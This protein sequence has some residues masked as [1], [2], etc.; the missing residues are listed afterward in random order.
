MTAC[1]IHWLLLIEWAK[2]IFIFRSLSLAVSTFAQFA[3]VMPY[4]ARNMS[5]LFDRRCSEKLFVCSKLSRAS[6]QVDCSYQVCANFSLTPPDSECLTF[7][8]LG[9]MPL[10]SS[11][12]RLRISL[13]KIR[14]STQVFLSS[15]GLCGCDVMWLAMWHT[16]RCTYMWALERLKLQLFPNA[17]WHFRFGNTYRSYQL[18]WWNYLSHK[19]P[20]IKWLCLH[21]LRLCVCV[22][23]W[24]IVETVSRIGE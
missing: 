4:N 2:L 16:H 7:S 3:K 15:R 8:K 13:R 23:E 1:R 14:S 20:E 9:R 11:K 10:K 18:N 24:W 6:F 17:K 21:Y 19:T 12:S 5:T 22:C